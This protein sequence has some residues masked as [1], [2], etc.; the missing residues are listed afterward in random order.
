M[1]T[2]WL[3]PNNKKLSNILKDNAYQQ[4]AIGVS[5]SKLCIE[6][7]VAK[8]ELNS[9]SEINAI[10]DHKKRV[11]NKARVIKISLTNLGE[12]ITDIYVTE[13]GTT[14]LENLSHNIIDIFIIET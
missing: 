4:K 5:V 2:K 10:S 1:T 6:T 13:T 3:K 8:L 9:K 11:S 14:E 7:K 12:H